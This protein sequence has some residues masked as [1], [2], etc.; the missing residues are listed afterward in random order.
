MLHCLGY[1]IQAL[2]PAN[3]SASHQ[4]PLQDSVQSEQH[5]E[6]NE[7]GGGVLMNMN[8][9]SNINSIPPG[10][11][12]TSITTVDG[13]DFS[14]PSLADVA[15]ASSSTERVNRMAVSSNV[16]NQSSRSFLSHQDWAILKREDVRLRTFDER[17]TAT[18]LSPLVLAQTGFFYLGVADVVQCAFCRG[19]VKDWEMNDDPRQEHRR[20]FPSCAFILGCK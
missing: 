13:S 19:V 10:S 6:Q 9:P 20:L 8:L 1:I 11:V 12:S 16:A 14:R 17:F 3:L 2:A 7:S 5:I 4:T 15:M 18:F